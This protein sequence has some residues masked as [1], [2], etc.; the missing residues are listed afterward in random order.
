MALLFKTALAVP[1]GQVL[2]GNTFGF[3]IGP[4]AS[5]SGL[6]VSVTHGQPMPAG[7]HEI[8]VPNRFDRFHDLQALQLKPY[9]DLR[10]VTKFSE[11]PFLEQCRALTS[12]IRYDVVMSTG[13]AGCGH[14]GGSLSIAELL[15][16]LYGGH[17]RFDST[18]PWHP[19]RDR[20]VLSK[21]HAAPA[22]YSIL[23]QAGY[24]DRGE[25]ERLRQIGSILQGHPDM[26]MTPGVDFGTGRLGL[27]MAA[28]V[29][30]AV[31]AKM[32]RKDFRTYVILGDGETQE[33]IVTEAAELAARLGLNNLIAF[34]DLNK[35]QI[36]GATDDVSLVN[37][38]QK[39]LAMGWQVI[40]A[41]GHNL[42]QL[43]L[44]IEIA[45]ASQNKPTVVIMHTVKGK[46]VSFMENNPEFHGVVPRGEKLAAAE[47][48]INQTRNEALAQ[49]LS[50]NMGNRRLPLVEKQLPLPQLTISPDEWAKEM[51]TRNAF[52]EWV[53]RAMRINPALVLLEADLEKS[54]MTYA[55]GKEFGI[56]NLNPEGRAIRVGIREQLMFAMGA[57]LATCGKIPVMAT[58]ATFVEAAT[59]IIRQTFG[60]YDLPGIIIG[61]HAG[62]QVGEDGPSHMS[63]T[64]IVTMRSFL[65]RRNQVFEPGDA[66]STACLLTDTANALI[67]GVNDGHSMGLTP[68]FFRLTRSP[69]PHISNAGRPDIGRGFRALLAEGLPPE[70]KEA[71]HY[72]IYPG[73]GKALV[74]FVASG[75]MVKIARRVTELV[76][77]NLDSTAR[78]H[79]IIDA[80]APSNPGLAN[81]AESIEIG[82]NAVVTLCDAVPE[83]LGDPVRFSLVQD[84]GRASDLIELGPEPD[85]IRSGKPGDV[86]DYLGL[87]PGK[88]AARVCR[89]SLP[90][91]KTLWLEAE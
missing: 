23:A 34:L 50:R 61:T 35:L 53:Q 73:S 89:I 75:A 2:S 13:K 82:V 9:L 7:K 14:P 18:R 87:S 38:V 58:F 10:G 36:D 24:L 54:V 63:L 44:A 4:Q 40:E 19:D 91:Q 48:E 16:V 22:L 5:T 39:W 28:A 11:D 84:G 60:K 33:G 47:A 70:V 90:E 8:M 41:D 1:R 79:R 29:G 31:A 43:D 80:F 77:T 65:R 42:A 26:K 66:Y 59:D 85:R 6:P 57:G 45:K 74:T 71:A 88:L 32:D 55:A 78:V 20:F 12:E 62:T 86:L 52:G 67:A 51:A 25:L 21:G 64:D 83:S 76:N 69:V 37:Q 72:E 27:G 15:A 3:L 68:V 56:F 81:V 17:L 49:E 46:G 30:M